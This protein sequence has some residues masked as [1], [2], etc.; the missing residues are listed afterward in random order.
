MRASLAWG[1]GLPPFALGG[2]AATHPIK[3]TTR[4]TDSETTPAAE[5]SPGYLHGYA[6]R[7]QERL[8]AQAE[9]WR[10]QVITDTSTRLAPGTRLLDVGVGVG[11]VLAILGEAFPRTQLAGVDISPEQIAFARTH[12]A[13]RDVTASLTVA[14][15]TALPY[16][17]DSFDHVWMMWFLEHLADPVAALREA[18][19]VLAPGGAITAIEADYS[20]A[21]A[22]PWSPEV[23]A[24]LDA[25]RQGMDA[26]GR[27]DAGTHVARW[28][29]E[30]GFTSITPGER[31]CAYDGD[32]A[33][34]AANYVAAVAED[35]VPTLAALPG[36]ASEAELWTGLRKL[37][38]LGEQPGAHIEWLLHKAQ[39]RA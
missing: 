6:T 11:A 16:P 17:D 35:L 14:D 38:A 27:S 1:D 39:A 33:D 2:Q 5:G 13:S 12:L 21:R 18:R 25:L 9:F 30:A 29:A 23:E 20:T 7:E 19:R 24:L 15:A 28:L 31:F 22:Q 32:D 26:T 34:V 3:D 37:R 8:V 4:M 36:T 10:E